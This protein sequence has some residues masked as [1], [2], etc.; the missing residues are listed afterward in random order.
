MPTD[1]S[2]QFSNQGQKLILGPHK[3]TVITHCCFWQLA[4]WPL[5][6]TAAAAGLHTQVF[7]YAQALESPTG[8]THTGES[9]SESTVWAENRS[10][11]MPGPLRSVWD[12]SN[13]LQGAVPRPKK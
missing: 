12:G 3:S 13:P 5:G 10:R 2:Y 9:G 11:S 6:T 1:S 8:A 4:R 7:G